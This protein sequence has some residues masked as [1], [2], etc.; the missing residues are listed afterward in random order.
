MVSGAGVRELL[1]AAGLDST[2][3]WRR[4]VESDEPHHDVTE[5]LLVVLR[6]GH[7]HDDEHAEVLD[8]GFEGRE[9][10]QNRDAFGQ[11]DTLIAPGQAKAAIAGACLS[12]KIAW[13][14]VE[15]LS[16]VKSEDASCWG[17]WVLISNH[18]GPAP[19]VVARLLRVSVKLN[20]SVPVSCPAGGDR[21]VIA[22]RA[23]TSPE[24]ASLSEILSC[25]EGSFAEHW[26][27]CRHMQ[28]IELSKQDVRKYVET[29]V[30]SGRCSKR[31]AQRPFGPRSMLDLTERS[32]HLADLA[33]PGSLWNAYLTIAFHV[34]RAGYQH[35][36]PQD[37]LFRAWFG[38][39]AA[40]KRRA[41][42]AACAL[43]SRK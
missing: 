32:W 34:D 25:A 21:A 41:F 31:S 16:S 30:A 20:L 29:V 38:T 10:I 22:G 15:P 23:A 28:E 1:V 35:E 5:Q 27:V 18:H 13:V 12:G 43:I 11:L 39:G 17:H 4:V 2:V 33:V 24:V 3:E 7:R 26:Q 14:A 9:P 37:R 19:A 40:V 6:G 36:S 42:E 8:Y